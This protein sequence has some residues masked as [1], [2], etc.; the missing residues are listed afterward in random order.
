[1]IEK[2]SQEKFK[3]TRLTLKIIGILSILIGSFY[4]IIGPLEFYTYYFFSEGGRFHYEGFG[5]GS[6]MFAFITVQIICYYLIAVIFLILGYGHLKIRCWIK[7]YSLILLKIWLLIGIPI[8]ITIIPLTAM[9]KNLSIISGIIFI[10]VLFSLYFIVP[11]FLLRFYNSDQLNGLLK[12]RGETDNW[13]ER[14]PERI[15]ILVFL[16]IFYAFCLHILILFRGIFPLF[17][18]FLQ[19][20]TGMMI[21][22]FTLFCLIVLIWGTFKQRIWAWWGSILFFLLWLISLIV[23]FIN[24]SYSDMLTILSFPTREMDAFQGLPLQGYHFILFFGIPLVA[25]IYLVCKSKRHYNK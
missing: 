5:M 7:N 2:S 13:F 9:H 8:I 6:F 21:I 12:L 22:E 19:N 23:T 16:F 14:Y 25:T 1:M 15:L 10:A 24:N 18:F 20:I 4:A 3:N 17:G 11:F